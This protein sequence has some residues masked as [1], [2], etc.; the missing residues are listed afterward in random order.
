MPRFSCRI[1]RTQIVKRGASKNA[2]GAGEGKGVALPMLERHPSEAYEVIRQAIIDRRSLNGVY[3]KCI[4]FF[5]PITLGRC[6]DGEP[7]VIAYQYAGRLPEGALPIGGEWACFRLD[8]LRWLQPNGDRWAM[9]PLGRRPAD[10]IV[11][12]DTD[13]TA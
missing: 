8:R 3:D 11:S 2:L 13:A 12:S 7:G 4:R 1:V 5:S 6:P 10:F 9:G